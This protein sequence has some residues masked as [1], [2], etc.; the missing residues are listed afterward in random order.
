VGVTIDETEADPP[1]VVDRA[2]V[3]PGPIASERMQSIPWRH[4]Q[5]I[6]GCGQVHVLQLARRTGRNVRG[7]AFRGTRQKEVPRTP[8]RERLYHL[9]V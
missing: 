4:L 5:I 6:Q 1:L 7:K 3:L 9:V 8:I 2:G